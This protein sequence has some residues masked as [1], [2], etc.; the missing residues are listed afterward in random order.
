MLV[1]MVA[2]TLTNQPLNSRDA[3]TVIS[4]FVAVNVSHILDGYSRDVMEGLQFG[5]QN[6]V[7]NFSSGITKAEMVQEM[8]TKAKT[9]WNSDDPVAKQQG[10]TALS[11]YARAYDLNLDH[12]I[13]DD[14]KLRSPQNVKLLQGLTN[15][16]SET[17]DRSPMVA[18]SRQ[19]FQGS[20]DAYESRNNSVVVAAGNSGDFTD[21]LANEFAKAGTNGLPADFEAS[22]LSNNSV[23]TVGALDGENVA[24]YSS[25]SGHVDVYADGTAADGTS[26]GTSFAAPKVSAVMASLHAANPHASSDE[27]QRM[28]QTELAKNVTTPD[29]DD[30]TALKVPPQSQPEPMEHSMAYGQDYYGMGYGHQCSCLDVM[31]G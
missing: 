2:H 1:D 8:F 27:I 18:R 7:R 31:V 20:V 19:R 21:F 30:I 9:A 26:V 12:L 16:V 24:S 28:L 15:T 23:T 11:N 10:Y 4:D 5:E 17:I 22:I 13:S 14:V 6:S 3:N 25:R 29:G